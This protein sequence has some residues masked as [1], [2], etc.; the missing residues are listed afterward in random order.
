MVV[1]KAYVEIVK[2]RQMLRV[3]FFDYL[4]RSASLRLG[5]YHDGGAVRVVGAEVKALGS[6]HF[7]EPDEYIRLYVFDKVAQVDRAV[8]VW[9]SGCDRYLS[10]HLFDSKGIQFQTS[11]I[12]TR[13]EKDGWD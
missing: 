2:I 10:G 5:P 3:I 1:V 11:V 7:L 9:K 4:F 12:V 13:R 8:S 6:P